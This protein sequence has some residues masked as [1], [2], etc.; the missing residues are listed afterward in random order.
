ML[1]RRARGREL[2][3]HASKRTNQVVRYVLA[4][5]ATKWRLEI[6]AVTVMD[7]HWHVCLTDPLGNIVEFQHDCHQFIARGLNAH[8]GEFESL[9]SSD[10]TSRVACEEPDDLIG[11]IAYTMA[12]PVEAGLLRYGKSWPGIRSAWP[13]KPRVIRRPP[14]FFRGKEDGGKWPAEATL[15]LKRPPG[16][17]ELADDELAAVIV[18]A[19]D[20]REARFRAERDAAGLP[21][22]GRRLVLAQSRHDRPRSWEPRFGISPGVACRNKWRRVERLRANRQWDTDYRLALARWRA[23]DR[24]VVFPAGTYKM[25]VIHGVH[26]AEAFG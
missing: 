25:R 24:E 20:E 2:L 6:H 3:L 13:C 17:D 15:E 7:N 23:G 1:T 10:Q 5:I 9:W 11:K 19:I 14:R 4:V 21:F 22:L 18:A 8:Y 16:Y 12:N 26:C